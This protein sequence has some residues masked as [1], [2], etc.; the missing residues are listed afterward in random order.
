MKK[1]QVS[2]LFWFFLAAVIIWQSLELRLGNFMTPGPGFI[3]LCMGI[4]MALISSVIFIRSTVLRTEKG[5]RLGISPEGAKRT[6]MLLLGIFLYALF[7]TYL[8]FA[9]STFLLLF[10]LS[11]GIG[12]QS[13]TLT[14]IWSLLLTILA[15]LLFY[16]ALKVQLP[17]GL[18]GF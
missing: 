2:G 9:L 12:R 17:T 15:Y 10:S 4:T 1:D 7:F 13:W 3:P 8:G 16:V 5:L 11:R 14:T 6:G 18:L